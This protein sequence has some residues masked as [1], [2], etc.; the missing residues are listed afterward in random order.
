MVERVEVTGAGDIP[1]TAWEHAADP[2]QH[3]GPDY[4]DH[5]YADHQHAD[6]QYTDQ[7]TPTQPPGQP[8]SHSTA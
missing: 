8:F 3:A 6:H 4:I 1:L 2:H 7:S 5:P